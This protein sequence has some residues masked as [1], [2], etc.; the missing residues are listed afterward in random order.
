MITK[1]HASEA[2]GYGYRIEYLGKQFLPERVSD[3]DF[4]G[5]FEGGRSFYVPFEW[6]GDTAKILSRPFSHLTK[7]ITVD[8][9]TF[10]PI[11]RLKKQF[12]NIEWRYITMPFNVDIALDSNSG[13]NFELTYDE[14]DEV[15][16]KL[17]QWGF[18]FFD[19]SVVK[20]ME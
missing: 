7:E 20:W 8:G 11:E 4:Y 1:K 6:F 13:I 9:E 16:G 3:L 14:M 15:L 18:S 5:S 2:F 10:V 19:D 17:K 12:Y